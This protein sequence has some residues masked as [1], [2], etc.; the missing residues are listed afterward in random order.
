VALQFVLEDIEGD[1][2]VVSVYNLLPDNLSQVKRIKKAGRICKQGEKVAMLEPFY[3]VM[4]C[5]GLQAQSNPRCCQH[6]C[7]LQVWSVTISASHCN[8]YSFQC[9]REACAR[10]SFV[11]ARHA[12]NNSHLL[13]TVL[14]SLKRSCQNPVWSC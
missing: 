10:T 2:V 9:G 1:V 12:R 4:S 3:K 13:L 11:T 14:H 8:R 6:H 7:R 5:T